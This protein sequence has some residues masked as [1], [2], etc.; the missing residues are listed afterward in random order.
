[1]Q[2]ISGLAIDD[3]G[4]ILMGLRRPDRLRPSL[5][6]LPGGKVDVTDATIMDA[7]Q[8]EWRE[9]LDVEV[10]IYLRDYLRSDRLSFDVDFE[11]ILYR[12]RLLGVP[13][14]VDHAQ[15]RWVEHEHAVRHLPCSPGYYVQYAAVRETVENVRK[16]RP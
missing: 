7:L 9:E 16:A 14:C 12:V 8:R 1:M 5:W 11:L 15:L 6:E 10:D 3:R 4:L 2:V 13:R